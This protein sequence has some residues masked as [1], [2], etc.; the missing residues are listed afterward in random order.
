MRESSFATFPKG[1]PLIGID[2]F[3]LSQRRRRVHHL[4]R[5]VWHRTHVRRRRSRRPRRDPHFLDQA[6]ALQGLAPS[7]RPHRPAVRGPALCALGWVGRQS[8]G[9]SQW[10]S[11]GP[12]GGARRRQQDGRSLLHAG[13]ALPGR[14]NSRTQSRRRAR[15][16]DPVLLEPVVRRRRQRRSPVRAAAKLFAPAESE[17]QLDLARSGRDARW[18]L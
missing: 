17:Q 9:D 1:L 2:P 15:R 7:D 10:R 14:P 11:A 5:Q 8:A 3:A 18:R 4:P 16:L 6:H 12:A 13:L